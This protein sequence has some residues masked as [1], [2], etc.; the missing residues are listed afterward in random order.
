[1]ALSGWFCTF[2]AP[3]V[4]RKASFS[5]IYANSKRRC[6]SI[7]IFAILRQRLTITAPSLL[8]FFEK[9]KAEQALDAVEVDCSRLEYISSAG[10]RVLLI[11]HKACTGGVSLHGENG[12]VGE[13]LEQTGF[14]SIFH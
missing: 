11:M 5:T 10:L 8:S 12:A 13:I 1:M 6:L 2:S 7:A 14:D 3:I 4:L 9:A